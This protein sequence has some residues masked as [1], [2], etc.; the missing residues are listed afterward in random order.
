MK[1]LIIEDDESIRAVLVEILKDQFKVA[2][3]QDG[4]KG[5]EMIKKFKPQLVITDFRMPK[6][7]GMEIVRYIR[8]SKLDIKIIMVSAD[9]D[10]IKPVAKAAGADI[11]IKKPFSI[12]EITEAVDLLLA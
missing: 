7:N 10:Y 1:I 8:L 5:I 4:A 12:E 11:V 9:A 6:K 2:T 3:A